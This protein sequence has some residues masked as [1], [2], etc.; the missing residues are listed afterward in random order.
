MTVQD[1]REGGPADGAPGTSGGVWTEPAGEPFIP[2]IHDPDSTDGLRLNLSWYLVGVGR[3]WSRL[4]DDRLRIADQTRPRWRVLAWARL[5]PGIKQTDLA[6]RIGIS[7]PALVGILDGLETAQLIERR[8]N[9]VDRRVKDIY[10]TD[11][12]TPVIEHISKEAAAIRDEILGDIPEDE[13]R[14]CLSVLKRLDGKVK[15]IARR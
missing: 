14:L 11:R 7:G 9:A 15:A 1:R 10:L 6:E 3:Q 5:L 2:N 8:A 12:A 13:L 4:L